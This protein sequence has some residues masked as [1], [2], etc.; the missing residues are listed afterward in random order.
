MKKL[1]IAAFAIAFAAVSQ[2]ATVTWAATNIAV[3]DGASAATCCAYLIDNTFAG[4]ADLDAAV[5]AVI[6]DGS[7]AKGVIKTADGITSG[8]TWK[9]GVTN[10]DLDKDNGYIA[11]Q[12]IDV[13]TVILDVNDAK[14]ADASYYMAMEKAQQS[15]NTS[16]KLS[17]SM[18]TQAGN[19]WTEVVPEPTSGLLMLLGMAGLALR[20]RRA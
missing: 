11:G 10:A 20:R 16:V 8:T 7:S 6:K 5:A 12:K 4:Y 9:V 3:L 13:Y 17:A 14:H 1:I 18:G 15:F 19:T 2:A